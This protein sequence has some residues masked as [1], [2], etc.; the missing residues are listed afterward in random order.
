M[1][2]PGMATKRMDRIQP[3]GPARMVAQGRAAVQIGGEF[4]SDRCLAPKSF[5]T[6]CKFSRPALSQTASSMEAINWHHSGGI[7]WQNRLPRCKGAL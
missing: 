7:S 3:L 4:A 6:L 2:D 5:E 1:A